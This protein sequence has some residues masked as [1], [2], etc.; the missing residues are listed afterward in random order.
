MAFLRI[1]ALTGIGSIA[2]SFFM[3]RR[4]LRS[5]PTICNCALTKATRVIITGATSGIGE[6]LARDILSLSTETT[7]VS[8]VLA[9]RD[10]VRAESLKSQWK[11]QYPTAELQVQQLDLGQVS[12]INQFVARMKH[13]APVNV[14]INNAGIMAAQPDENQLMDRSMLVNFFGTALLTRRALE[15]Q[16]LH[17]GRVVFVSSS[18]AQKGQLSVK[19]S[20]QISLF[21][22]FSL[23]LCS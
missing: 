4:L 21:N 3:I 2:L 13:T 22:Q 20:S 5:A 11:S 6:A 17:E 12:S 14:L 19:V 10:S 15:E 7:P 9:C 23:K 1:L 8:L 16:I 18:L